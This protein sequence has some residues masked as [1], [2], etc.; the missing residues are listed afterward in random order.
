MLHNDSLNKDVRIF[1]A[2]AVMLQS[3][4]EGVLPRQICLQ[5]SYFVFVFQQVLYRKL[6]LM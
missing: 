5:V 1:V 2:M 6:N 4:F 3:S